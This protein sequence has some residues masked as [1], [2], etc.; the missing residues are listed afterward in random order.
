MTKNTTMAAFPG[1]GFKTALAKILALSD[2]TE[3]VQICPQ[4]YGVLDEAMIDSLR[5]SG[6][7]LRP[8]ANV[9]IPWNGS[10]RIDASMPWEVTRPYFVTL[11]GLARRMNASAYSLHAGERRDPLPHVF[12]RVR[13]IEDLFGVPVALEGHYPTPDGTF[14]L[15]S[16]QEYEILLHSGL[17]MAI[18]LS[19]LN[20]VATVHGRRDDLVQALLNHPKTIEIHVSGNDGHR[21]SHFLSTGKEWW[22]PLL[23]ACPPRP[24]LVVFDEGKISSPEMERRIERHCVSRI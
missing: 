7:K 19:H 15:D 20:I 10:R 5:D 6:L 17:H 22:V 12:D 11:A 18:D 3:E 2:G 13:R 4:N 14:H 8:H 24:G 21:D 1:F 9:R 16:W 23:H